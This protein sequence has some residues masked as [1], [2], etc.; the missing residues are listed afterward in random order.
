M[1]TD[2]STKTGRRDGR[3]AVLG[4]IGR[5]ATPPRVTAAAGV[6]A[7]GAAAYALWRKEEWRNGLT[8]FGRSL[9]D[10]AR[11]MPGGTAE[12]KRKGASSENRAGRAAPAVA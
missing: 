2:G 3:Q 8:S 11:S 10:R 7:L 1:K 5:E 12:P 9:A 6:I 4:K